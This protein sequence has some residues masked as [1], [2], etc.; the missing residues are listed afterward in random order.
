MGSLE[1][2]ETPPD[3]LVVIELGGL[4]FSVY[5]LNN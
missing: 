5:G 4:G 1:G 2:Q 3:T